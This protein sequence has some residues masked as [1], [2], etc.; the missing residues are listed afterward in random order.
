[1]V[2]RLADKSNFGGK[3]DEWAHKRDVLHAHCKD[4]GRDPSEIELTWS[5]EVC[6]RDT[7]AELRAL[8]DAGKASRWGEPYDSWQAGNLV[9]T[10]EQVCEKI[11]AYIDL[12]C[13]YFVPWCSDYPD[14]TTLRVFAE[15][16][17]P[18]FK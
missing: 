7:E 18:E 6:V 11:R 4:V 9:G 13:T 12:G 8:V 1:M 14:D 17:M 2:A 16:V 3:P 15:K 10:P 5:P